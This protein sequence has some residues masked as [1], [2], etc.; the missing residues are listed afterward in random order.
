MAAAK[1]RCNFGLDLFLGSPRSAAGKSIDELEKLLSLFYARYNAEK[2][3]TV[4][5]L[6]AQF[7][8]KEETLNRLL[9]ERYEA[10]LNDILLAIQGNPEV[11]EG[12][13]P[14]QEN[15]SMIPI[16]SG[17]FDEASSTSH[18]PSHEENSKW[19][20]TMSSIDSTVTKSDVSSAPNLSAIVKATSKAL[21]AALQENQELK[22]VNA[23]LCAQLEQ[24]YP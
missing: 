15:D 12:F 17:N 11:N 21:K 3:A 1:G 4:K 16:P 9:K 24:R 14:N 19:E 2:L 18:Y 10:D 20:A 6:A 5:A 8:G 22:A 7:L 13:H 23:D